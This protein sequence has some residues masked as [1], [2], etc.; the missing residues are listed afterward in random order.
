MARAAGSIG[1]SGLGARSAIPAAVLAVVGALLA[2]LM[3]PAVGL[4][5]A[6]TALARL[7]LQREVWLAAFA[8]SLGSVMATALAESGVYVIGV[9][10][11]DVPVTA[12]APYVFGALMVASLL[13]AGPGAVALLRRRPALESVGVLTVVLA[14]L[15]L[16]A[17]ASFAA[18]AGM[19]L[20]AY[21]G[22]ATE[23]LAAQAGMGEELAQVARAMWPGVV[24]T[25]AA[26]AAFFAVVG[27]SR[28]AARLGASLNRMPP[29][30]ALDLDPRVAV[31][32]I[33]AVALLAAGRFVQ[34]SVWLTPAGENVLIVARWVFFLQGLAVFAGLYQRGK[35][36][37]P[38]RLFGFALL[39]VTEAYVPLVSLTGL[40]DVWLNIRRLPREGSAPDE[41]ETPSGV[42]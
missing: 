41:R 36:K 9:L 35:V 1:P 6:G 32:P 21:V 13:A 3:H 27:V 24:V 31:L 34:E 12:R 37:R 20:L 10:L 2:V 14:G 22:Q 5:I 8:L 17:L 23:S 7:V 11:L 42:A 18:G 19:S 16:A 29:M 4:P 40:A 39:G 38:M 33:V 30:P 25:M 26:A 15:Q 28:T